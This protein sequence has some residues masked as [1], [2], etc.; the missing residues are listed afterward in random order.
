[1]LTDL[2]FEQ[3]SSDRPCHAEL[4]DSASPCTTHFVA[5]KAIAGGDA[6]RRYSILQLIGVGKV[7][8]KAWIRKPCPGLTRSIVVPLA[9]CQFLDFACHDVTHGGL[10]QSRT[11]LAAVW[12]NHKLLTFGGR[13]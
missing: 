4:L 8:G 1:M 12:R 7:K 2:A 3:A 11:R 10:R 9:I 5:D 6:E 13:W